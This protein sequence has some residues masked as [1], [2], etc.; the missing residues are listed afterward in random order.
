MIR[1][2]P[3]LLP[4]YSVGQALACF[5]QDPIIA[6]NQK[7]A[8]WINDNLYSK[9]FNEN[10]KAAH[11]VCAYSLVKSVEN[12]KN[13]LIAKSNRNN[14][15][16]SEEE[17]L[18]YF[19]QRGSIFLLASAIVSCLEIMIGKKILNTYRISFGNT[20][21]K[22]AEELWG[23]IVTVTLPFCAQLTK[24]LQGGLKNASTVKDSIGIF[25]SLVQATAIQNKPIFDEF[26]SKVSPP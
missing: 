21:P 9:Y 20:S 6:Y 18:N 1:R 8:I 14:L 4:S 17:Y 7:T 5:H 24:A 26:A 12:K 23:N 10:T 15:T 22:Q 2:R 25:R 11:I 3:N 16:S 19:R 13:E